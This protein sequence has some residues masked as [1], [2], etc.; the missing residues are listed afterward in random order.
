[1]S[2]TNSNS[3]SD[4]VIEISDGF[5]LDITFVERFE[6]TDGGSFEYPHQS[7]DLK[8]G[9]VPVFLANA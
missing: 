3:G 7:G 6:F 4:T 5:N 8:Y 2:S 9:A 1:M